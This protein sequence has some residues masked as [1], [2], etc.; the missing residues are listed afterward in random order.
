MKE[1]ILI[2]VLQQSQ[3]LQKIVKHQAKINT[4]HILSRFKYHNNLS[5]WI[6]RGERVSGEVAFFF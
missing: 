3:Q 6:D 1:V 5:F 2:L 4:F